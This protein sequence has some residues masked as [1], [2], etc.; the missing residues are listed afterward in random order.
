MPSTHLVRARAQICRDNPVVCGES[1]N[2]DED[3]NLLPNPDAYPN[4][5]S[6]SEV[7]NDRAREMYASIRPMVTLRHGISSDARAI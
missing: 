4:R 7:I 5:K 6:L 1:G 2:L 3:G